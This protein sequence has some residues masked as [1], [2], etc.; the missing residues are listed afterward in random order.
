MLVQKMELEDLVNNVDYGAMYSDSNPSKFALMFVNFIKLVNGDKGE[1]NT[2]PIVHLD[3][4]DQLNDHSHNLYVAARGLAK[5]TINIEYM[6][7]FIATYGGLPI[8]G[9]EDI[10]VGMF[11]ADTMNNGVKNL[12]IN[13]QARYD[14]SEFLQQYLPVAKI[15]EDTFEFINA[16]NHKLYVKGFGV[17]SGVRG[18]KAYGKRPSFALLD[19]LMTDENAASPTITDKIEKIVYGAVEQALYADRKKGQRKLVIWAGTPFNKKDPLYKAAGSDAWNTRTYPICE[20]FPCLK[21]D[22]KG[23]W[24]DR[25][26]YDSVKAEYNRLMSLGRVDLFNQELMLRIISDD[27]RLVTKT[28]I[29]EYSRDNVLRNKDRYNFYITTDFATSEKESADYSVIIVWAYTHNGDWLLV[30]GICKKQLMDANIDDLFRFVRVYNPMEVAV[31]VS[32]Q[33][34]GFISWIYEEMGRKNTYFTLASDK[35]SREPGIRPSTDKFTRFNVALPLFKAKKIWLPKELKETTLYAEFM[36]EVLFVTTSG[37]KSK[38]DDV[39]DN[40]SQL[41]L[42]NAW[43]PSEDQAVVTGDGIYEDYEMEEKYSRLNSYIV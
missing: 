13:L 23:G 14:N 37:M 31:E 7:L 3:M 21:K 6:I 26:P 2:T 4:L 24:E 12:R 19:D 20:K 10:S 33:Q 38:N 15:Q 25:F 27:D 30:D 9:Y 28:D 42:L 35:K 34:G 39:L 1:E 8:P 16:S 18:F 36:D 43:K 32:G 11:V 17:S 40:I 22:F 41:P 29:I 5:T